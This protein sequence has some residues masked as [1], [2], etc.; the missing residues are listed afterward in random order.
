MSDAMIFTDPLH[1]QAR[2]VMQQVH[3]LTSWWI[4]S[5]AS[6]IDGMAAKAV[7]Y[8][9]TDLRDLGRMIYEMAGRPQP[10]D[11]VATETGIAFYAA[12]KLGRIVAAIKEGRRP[13]EDTW[14]DLGVYSRMA[15]RVR[16]TGG[17]PGAA[18][19]DGVELIPL[20]SHHT[21]VDLIPPGTPPGLTLS[22]DGKLLNWLG[23]NYVR[24]DTV[25]LQIDDF[26]PPPR[27]THPSDPDLSDPGRYDGEPPF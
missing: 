19:D 27:N 4:D 24:Q 10:D 26:T 15:Q 8:G 9:A 6:E 18:V 2:L 12:G 16:Q 7:E 25:A 14:L 22:D 23:E 1:D 21:P 17:W 11:G 3:E 5:A 20:N 13:S